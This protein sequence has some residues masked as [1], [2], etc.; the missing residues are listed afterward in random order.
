MVWNLPNALTWARIAAI[1]LIVVLFYM[2]YPWADPAAGLL[3]V[4]AGITDS[5]DG[6]FARRFGQISRLGAFLDP[7]ADKL[8]V[9]VALV[10]LVSKDPHT[11]IVLTAA[12]IIGREITISALREW[13]AEIGARRKVAVSQLGKYKTVLQI[14]GLSMMLYRWPLFGLPTYRVGVW[15]TMI[16]AAA[17]LVSMVAYLR[18][19]WPELRAQPSEYRL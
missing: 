19:A 15:M 13:M 3:F 1:P 8:I 12:I 11:L 4:A 16:A 14:I 9:A 2:P 6:Y 7:V 5:L 18:V 10:L 17:T